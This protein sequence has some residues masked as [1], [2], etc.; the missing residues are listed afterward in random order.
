MKKLLALSI[1]ACT[2]AAYSCANEVDLKDMQRYQ[3]CVFNN[4]TYQCLNSQHCCEG[5]CVT[6]SERN[7]STCGAKCSEFESC[8]RV[9]PITDTIINSSS[10]PDA[11]TTDDISENQDFHYACLCDGKTCSKTCCSGSCVDVKTDSANCGKCGN[12]CGKNMICSDGTCQSNCPTPMIACTVGDNTTCLD[13][14]HDPDNCGECGVKCPDRNDQTLHIRDSYCSNKKCE[15]VCEDGYIN[16]NGL[17]SDG[18]ETSIKKCNNGKLDPGEICDGSNFVPNACIVA[19]GSGAQQ[20]S[21]DSLKCKD[22][23][24]GLADGSCSKIDPDSGNCGNGNL[25]PGEICDYNHINTSHKECSELLNAPAAIGTAPCTK[26]CKYDASRCVYCGDGIITGSETCDGNAFKNGVSKCAEYDASKYV[27]GNLVCRSCQISTENCV[28]K[29][30]EGKASCG[31][32]AESIDT[33]QNGEFVNTPCPKDKSKCLDGETPQCVECLTDADCNNA[34]MTCKENA[35]KQKASTQLYTDD[36][37]WIKNSNTSNYTTNVGSKTYP[38]YS[39]SVTAR[40]DLSLNANCEAKDKNGNPLK[41]I[42]L[43]TTKSD[44][45]KVEVSNIKGGLGKVYFDYK[46]YDESVNVKVTCVNDSSS[47]SVTYSGSKTCADA[48]TSSEKTPIVINH[49]SCTA[50]T[51]TA[52]KRIVLYNLSWTPAQ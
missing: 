32:D 42:I 5:V 23:C 35:C 27:S 11:D 9:S 36:F 50:F 12:S 14:N 30:T 3:T 25:D 17:L 38:D 10:A 40:T 52:D 31:S 33:C 47:K 29:C 18:C 43:N 45:S 26:E 28:E 8:D 2:L 15:I 6:P 20:I 4:K 41:G 39:I 51:L 13:V 24:S 34:Q 21:Q 48:L 37:M 49:S 44:T 19:F 7:C 46:N 22:D 16:D 1:L